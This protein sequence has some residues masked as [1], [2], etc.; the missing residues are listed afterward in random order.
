[1]KRFLLWL[2]CLIVFSG[3][4]LI[5]PRIFRNLGEAR[6]SRLGQSTGGGGSGGQCPDCLTDLTA[7]YAFEGTADDSTGVY[8]GTWTGTATYPAG[9]IG[10]GASKGVPS[11]YITV[12]ALPLDTTWSVSVWTN[13]TAP[14]TFG[15]ILTG[16]TYQGI[17][18]RN[19]NKYM[20]Y[21]AGQFVTT[22]ND[23]HGGT[24]SHIVFTYDGVNLFMILNDG[25]PAGIAVPASAFTPSEILT[26]AVN[27]EYVGSI[28]ELAV[29]DEVITAG[30]ITSLYQGGAGLTYSDF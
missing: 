7:Y 12:S 11:A 9:K 4:G 6:I 23:P 25:T 21:Q 28:D 22:I 14:A 24:W 3:Q 8:N 26:A 10:T 18:T 2:L 1:M 19:D 20:Y 30:V 5:R 13:S 16:A 15:G 27:A 29:Y 17:H